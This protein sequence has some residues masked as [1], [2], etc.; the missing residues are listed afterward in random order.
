MCIVMLPWVVQHTFCPGFKGL[1][2]FFWHIQ[3]V[4]YVLQGV[5]FHKVWGHLYLVRLWGLVCW[6]SFILVGLLALLDLAAGVGLPAWVSHVY[7]RIHGCL[8][9]APQ[10]TLGH[11]GPQ[12][13]GILHH[14]S[15]SLALMGVSHQMLGASRPLHR[16]AGFFV[17]WE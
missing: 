7:I 9:L 2:H 15:Q 11:L 16:M 17:I 3:Y 1:Y 14:Q 5:M 13:G 6:H 8:A 4:W 12:V 10:T